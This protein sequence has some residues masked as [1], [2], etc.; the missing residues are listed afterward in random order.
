MATDLLVIGRD[1][2]PRSRD[3]Y[4]LERE[5]ASVGFLPSGVIPD[6]RQ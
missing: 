4:Q 6:V 3:P 5:I 1:A 2:V